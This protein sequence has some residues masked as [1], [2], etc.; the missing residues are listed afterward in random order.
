MGYRAEAF[1]NVLGAD[2]IRMLSVRITVQHVDFIEICSPSFLSLVPTR[3]P[4][5]ASVLLWPQKYPFP[6]MISPLGSGASIPHPR[7][8]CRKVC[9]PSLG[10]EV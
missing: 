8:K 3:S 6:E 10:N 2:A 4:S 5:G 1:L 7:D 9:E